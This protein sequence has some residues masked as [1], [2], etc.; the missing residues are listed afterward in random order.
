[1]V[2]T[3]LLIIWRSGSR[4]LS[5]DICLVSINTHLREDLYAC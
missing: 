5:I 4:N 3:L 1:M 2:L